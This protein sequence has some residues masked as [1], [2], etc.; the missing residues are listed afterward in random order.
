MLISNVIPQSVQ[1]KH[2]HTV[3]EIC[4]W[5]YAFIT[6]E[7]KAHQSPKY[8]IVPCVFTTVL[9]GKLQPEVNNNIQYKLQSILLPTVSTVK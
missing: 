9:K 1:N 6:T 3:R 4:I 8:G 5:C 7:E 2:T